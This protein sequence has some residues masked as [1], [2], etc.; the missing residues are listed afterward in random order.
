MKSES[1]LA[2]ISTLS[3]Q[4]D[5]SVHLLFGLFSLVTLMANI[6]IKD[7][8][9]VVCTAAWYAK[10]QPTV[11]DA[12]ALV[13]RCL[14]SSCHFQTSES[15]TDI[16]KIPRSLF[17]RLTTPCATRPEWV[18]SSLGLHDML[19]NLAEWCGGVYHDSYCGQYGNPPV[20]GSPWLIGG[21]QNFRVLRGGS[22]YCHSEELRF[23]SRR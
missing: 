16:V 8:T 20:D 23:T 6:L 21:E 1:R 18:K 12:L 2:H 10:E 13:R 15:E 19:G 11:S 22:W 17:E 7:Q 3:F 9:K 4:L 14:W 5:S